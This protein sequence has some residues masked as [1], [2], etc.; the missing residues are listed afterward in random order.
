[1]TTQTIETCSLHGE[2]PGRMMV[3]HVRHAVIV[4]LETSLSVTETEVTLCKGV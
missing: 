1:M 4:F 2:I 3:F